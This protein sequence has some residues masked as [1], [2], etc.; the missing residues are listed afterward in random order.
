ME[1]WAQPDAW[2]RPTP[3]QL[4]EVAA[5]CRPAHAVR[6][7]DEDAKRF[8][9]LLLNTQLALLRS[10]LALA[11]LQTKVQQVANSL[12]G[13]SQHAQRART[14]AADRGRGGR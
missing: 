11:R 13:E 10:E 8:D 5:T 4:A 12:A 7:D 1:A 14:P 3:E 6:D 2:K 9:A